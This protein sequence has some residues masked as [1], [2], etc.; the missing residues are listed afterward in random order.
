MIPQLSSR[1]GLNW[2]MSQMVGELCVGH[3]YIG[4]GDMGGMKP[5]DSPVFTGRLGADLA[6]DPG[7]RPI[8]LRNDLRPQCVQP[9]HRGA[10]GAP[11]HRLEGRGLT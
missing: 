7:R 5:A 4:G 3:A 11:R 6:Y 2:L 1:A 10:A 8:P 9:R